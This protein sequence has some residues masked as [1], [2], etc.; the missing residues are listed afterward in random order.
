MSELPKT[1]DPA[2]I[3][4][5]WYAHWEANGLFRPDRPGAQPWTIVN[6]PPNVTGSL[7]IGHALDNTLQDILVRH[8]RRSGVAGG[9]LFALIDRSGTVCVRVG[10]NFFRPFFRGPADRFF[11]RLPGLRRMAHR[12]QIQGTEGHQ[13]HRSGGPNPPAPGRSR[14]GIE[15]NTAPQPSDRVFE[16]SIRSTEMPGIAAASRPTP[17]APP[18]SASSP[19]S[20]A[21]VPRS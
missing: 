6:P 11:R 17:M 2:D 8:A 9:R 1:F 16:M 4:Q 20:T 19:G 13:G 10:R 7:H 5:R 15:D 21:S 14:H 3:E 12:T 18:T